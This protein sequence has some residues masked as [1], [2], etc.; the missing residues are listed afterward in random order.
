MQCFFKLAG[1]YADF[2]FGMGIYLKG[3]LING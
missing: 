3:E 1:G 2:F